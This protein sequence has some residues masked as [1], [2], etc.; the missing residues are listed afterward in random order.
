M[1]KAIPHISVYNWKKSPFSSRP[2]DYLTFSLTLFLLLCFN[3]QLSCLLQVKIHI[4]CSVKVNGS[5]RSDFSFLRFLSLPWNSHLMTD[6]H[7]GCYSVFP[8]YMQSIFWKN[9]ETTSA[10]NGFSDR[11]CKTKTS[12]NCITFLGTFCPLSNSGHVSSSWNNT[13]FI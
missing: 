7:V 2:K 12:L 6:E 9:T 13:L 3:N 10:G 1:G 5:H 4:K 8:V 11:N